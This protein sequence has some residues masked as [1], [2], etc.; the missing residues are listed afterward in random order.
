MPCNL[1]PAVDYWRTDLLIDEYSKQQHRQQHSHNHIPLGRRRIGRGGRV[2]IDR[3]TLRRQHGQ[4]DTRWAFDNFA[5]LSEE[6]DFEKWRPKEQSF[7]WAPFSAVDSDTNAM[8]IDSMPVND[9]QPPIVF[10][11]ALDDPILMIN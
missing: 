3:P 8:Q 1:H 9:K 5:E 7:N 11:S 2:L 4:A 6:E 10:N